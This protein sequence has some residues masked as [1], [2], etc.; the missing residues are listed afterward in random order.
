MSR[1]RIVLS[2]CMSRSIGFEPGTVSVP[3][4]CFLGIVDECADI[5]L[6]LMI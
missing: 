1:T 4:V 5:C 3:I 6:Y 2:M